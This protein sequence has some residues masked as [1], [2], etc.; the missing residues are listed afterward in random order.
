ME[1]ARAS[2]LSPPL[3]CLNPSSSGQPHSLF[4]LKVL[5]NSKGQNN[6]LNCQKILAQLSFSV[7][8]GI[9]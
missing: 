6:C 4:S 3:S 5:G 9:G 8:E 7:T 1:D 2:F